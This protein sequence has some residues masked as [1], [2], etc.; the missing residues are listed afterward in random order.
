MGDYTFLL[1][2]GGGGREYAGVGF[3][4]ES[5][6]VK[7]TIGIQSHGPREA[8]LALR[9]SPRDLYVASRYAPQPG[10]SLDERERFFGQRSDPVE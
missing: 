6:L 2:G 10:R 1:F 7:A 4:I 8:W 3:V 9:A 5:R